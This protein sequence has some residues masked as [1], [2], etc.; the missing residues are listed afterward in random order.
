MILLPST[1]RKESIPPISSRFFLCL[2][3]TCSHTRAFSAMAPYTPDPDHPNKESPG[4]C[5]NY[6]K[7]RSVSRPSRAWP[8]IKHHR[9]HQA[10]PN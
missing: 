2:S 6:M 10:Q 9:R 5:H 1:I 7:C 3:C 8:Q 4:P